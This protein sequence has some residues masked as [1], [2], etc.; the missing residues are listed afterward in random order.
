MFSDPSIHL[1]GNIS[2]ASGSYKHLRR[3][4]REEREE[5]GGGRMGPYPLTLRMFSLFTASLDHHDTLQQGWSSLSPCKTSQHLFFLS[6][7]VHGSAYSSPPSSSA[8]CVLV[9]LATGDI[10]WSRAGSKGLVHAEGWLSLCLILT[11]GLGAWGLTS[12][13]HRSLSLC[14][15]CSDSPAL[16]AGWKILFG[17]DV[18]GCNTQL[19]SLIQTNHRSRYLPLLAA[20]NRCRCTSPAKWACVFHQ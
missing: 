20:D 13:R 8:R 2:D 6:Q 9:S 17:K 5:E 19:C 3:Y 14:P 7:P 10:I 12:A 4:N 1:S 18:K 15:R 11:A 16:S